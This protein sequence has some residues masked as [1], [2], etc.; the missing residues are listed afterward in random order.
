MGYHIL[1]S[2]VEMLQEF[3]EE[4]SEYVVKFEEALLQLESADEKIELLNSVFRYIHNIKGLSKFLELT[5]ITDFSHNVETL[6]DHL[7]KGSAAL[8]SDVI[9]LLLASSD[10]LGEMMNTLRVACESY[11]GGDLYI[12]K[13]AVDD[14]AVVVDRIKELLDSSQCEICDEDPVAEAEEEVAA[15]EPVQDDDSLLAF[16]SEKAGMAVLEEFIVEA[17]EHLEVIIGQ[18]LPAL[19]EDKQNEAALAELFRRVHTLKGLLGLVHSTQEEASGLRGLLKE[20][21]EVFQEIEGILQRV[22]SGELP[23][24]ERIVS[25][26]FAGMDGIERFI[27]AGKSGEL[28]A[29]GADVLLEEW[30]RVNTRKTDL[31]QRQG[32][33]PAQ[34][35]AQQAA[36]TPEKPAKA[37]MAVAGTIRVSEEKINRLMSI[38]GEMA[39]GRN[40]LNELAR[41]LLLE[42]NLPSLA[43]EVTQS[44]QWLSRIYSELEDTVMSMRMRAIKGL[45]QKFP[46]VVRDIGLNRGKRIVLQMEGEETELDKKI[47]EEISEPLMHIV[48]NAADHGIEPVEE[49]LANGKD[50]VGRITLRAYSLGKHIVIEVEDDGRGIDAEKVKAKAMEKGFISQEH[51]EVMSREQALQLIFLPGLSTA[52][53]ITDISGRG[54]GMDVVKAKITDLKGTIAVESQCGKGTRITIQLPLTL[55]VSQGL[56]VEAAGQHMIFPLENVVETVKIPRKEI[57]NFNG[58]MLVCHRDEILGV[59]FLADIM[60]LDASTPGEYVPVVIVTDNRVRMGFAV[61]RLLGQQDVL[62]KSLPDYMPVFP[63]VGGAA[64]LGDGSIAL[65]F[66][67]VEL[68]RI[69]SSFTKDTQSEAKNSS[70]TAG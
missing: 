53:T 54:V 57:K 19:D 32:I 8:S 7:R 17:E 49:R 61:D 30:H 68:V 39:L 45:F 33:E 34:A 31:E 38:T 51:A 60:G 23:V 62:V 50:P 63:A 16:V 55:V 47:I 36:G 48:R 35:E 41:R 11:S 70:V 18:I 9:T 52:K 3:I 27:E 66:N 14:A 5:E 24:T 67:P 10:A 4:C 40:M 28:E 59:A 42:Y 1:E 43:R 44:S 22:Q 29:I 15:A 25:L 12:E 64:I 65:V 26:C 21:I 58:R 69:A 13:L 20:L 2:D 46:R 37:K 56:V 6:L